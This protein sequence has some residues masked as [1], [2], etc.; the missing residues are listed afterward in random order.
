VIWLV[1][2]VLQVIM[3]IGLLKLKAW[4]RI[5]SICYCAFFVFNSF[6]MLI[7]GSQARFEEAQAEIR[8]IF[9]IPTLTPNQVHFPMWFGLIFSLPLFGLQLWFLITNKEAFAPVPQA[10]DAH[11]AST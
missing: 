5:T 10:P 7:P 6:A 8:R 9:A 2:C 4:A 1:M 11:G 3:G